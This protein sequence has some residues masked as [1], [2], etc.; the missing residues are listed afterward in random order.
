MPAEAANANES[1]RLERFEI[2]VRHNDVT[3]SFEVRPSTPH[4]GI[5]HLSIAFMHSHGEG[6]G[7]SK[8]GTDLIFPREFVGLPIAGST[9][10]VHDDFGVI[11]ANDNLSA[12]I[13]GQVTD[14]PGSFFFQKGFILDD[15]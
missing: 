15:A 12:V 9:T 2:V 5:K 11:S 4:S 13:T 8:G 7:I 1:V 10:V 6:L 3:V 14:A